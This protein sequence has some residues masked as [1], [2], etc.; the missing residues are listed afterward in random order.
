MNTMTGTLSPDQMMQQQRLVE[1]LRAPQVQQMAQAQSHGGQLAAAPQSA[2][3]AAPVG[4]A[5]GNMGNN[6]L[7]NM[8]TANKYGTN[9]F[10]QQT[11]MLAAQDAAFV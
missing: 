1:A 8:Q 10:S 3:W 5:L 9:P 11:D 6:A 2:N 7:F 4:Q